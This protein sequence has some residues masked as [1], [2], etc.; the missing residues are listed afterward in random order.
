MKF[1]LLPL[2]IF[3]SLTSF[4]QSLE[5][6]REALIKFYN[7]TNGPQWTNS[8]GWNTNTSPCGWYGVICEGERV[9]NLAFYNNNLSGTIPKEIQNLPELNR[10]SLSG[11][12]SGIIPTEIGNLTKLQY[13]YLTS[14]NLSGNI[15]SSIGN[16]NNLIE[17]GIRSTSISGE[18]PTEI[19]SLPNLT[20]L[21]LNQNRLTGSLP[22]S[23]SH[24]IK[25]ETLNL[26]GNQLSGNLPDAF[27]GLLQ[28]KYIYLQNNLFSGNIPASLGKAPSLWVIDLSYNQFTGTIPAE[29]SNLTSV[30]SLKATNNQLSGGIPSELGQML[31]LEELYL[32]A[33]QFDGSIPASLG[34]LRNLFRLNLAANRLTGGIPSE[35]GNFPRINYLFLDS[36]ALTGSIPGAVANLKT[37]NWLDISSNQLSG[38]IP[39]FPYMPTYGIFNIYSNKFTFNGMESNKSKL[40]L[41]SPQ[42]LIPFV[43]NNKTLSVNAGETQAWNTYRWYRN[44]S[45]IA[46]NKGVNSLAMTDNG[47]YRVEVTN[48][49]LPGLV[50]YSNS[51]TFSA[52]PLPVKLVNFIGKKT[53]KGNVISWNTTIEINNAGFELERSADAKSYVTIAKIDGNGTSKTTNNYVFTDQNPL[54]NSYYRL[55]QIDYDG[56]TTFSRAIH[57]QTE[58]GKLKVYPN[59]AKSDFTVENSD[60]QGLVSIYDLRGQKVV[61]KPGSNI[62][63][64][65]I[66]NFNSGA[67]IIQSGN[68]S[69]KVLIEK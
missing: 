49:I 31:A 30:F 19:F 2:F 67:Y 59:P 55:K 20:I 62:L 25:L 34:N 32:Q 50:L 41:Y 46:L 8:S 35:F 1:L 16:L 4:S 11:T 61:E 27:A 22:A 48:D 14:P 26:S 45:Q 36:N 63:I 38:T 15:P 52:N 3:L 69:V 28:T 66:D 13:L 6:D 21:D 17:L 39:D 51:Y 5:T 60:E 57:V 44:N 58:L 12:F 65:K 54:K 42:A 56:T 68:E 53:D 7:A 33:N 40:D 47:D 29:F 37:L 9:A 43:I 64:F 24:A 18:I 23:L 10:L